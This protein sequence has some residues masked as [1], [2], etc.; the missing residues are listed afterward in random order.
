MTIIST[1]SGTAP[2]PGPRRVRGHDPV[3]VLC[4]L[5][6]ER[7]EA[8]Q[9]GFREAWESVDELRLAPLLADGWK[10]RREAAAGQSAA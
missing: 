8:W 10:Q 4:Q 6:D 1:R 9:P 2:D 3:A 7:R 5:L